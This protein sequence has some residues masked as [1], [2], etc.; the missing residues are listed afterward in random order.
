MYMQLLT[1]PEFLAHVGYVCVS[2]LGFTVTPMFYALELFALAYR[3]VI[4]NEVISAI[5]RCV[6]CNH[7]AGS[8]V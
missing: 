4:F 1:S 2:V 8:T 3:V 7:V 6:G 5:V